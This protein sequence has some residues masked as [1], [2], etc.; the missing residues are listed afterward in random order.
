MLTRM[1]SYFSRLKMPVVGAVSA[2]VIGVGVGSAKP[3]IETVINGRASSVTE[4]LAGSADG[5]NS[6]T[7]AVTPTYV[8]GAAIAGG[9]LDVNTNTPSDV[10]GLSSTSE[11][12]DCR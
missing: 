8:P 9:V 2:A 6:C 1:P 11:S 10:S 12:S 7:V 5:T 4:G 3:G